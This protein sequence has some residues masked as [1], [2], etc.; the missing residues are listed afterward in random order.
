M[1][2]FTVYKA[3]S[4][5]ARPS[6]PPPPWTGPSLTLPGAIA[7]FSR[8]WSPGPELQPVPHQHGPQATGRPRLSCLHPPGLCPGSQKGTELGCRGH[9]SPHVGMGTSRY[10]GTRNL[11]SEKTPLLEGQQPPLTAP[12]RRKRAKGG[13]RKQEGIPRRCKVCN[14]QLEGPLPVGLEMTSRGEVRPQGESSST[15]GPAMCNHPPLSSYA[16]RMAENSV[17][18]EHLPDP[19]QPSFVAQRT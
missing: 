3:P 15:S 12:P 7:P 9:H 8:H 6:S 17:W 1:Q 11:V 18:S 19:C 10:L 13:P 2:N 14:D 16:V 4:H 5:L